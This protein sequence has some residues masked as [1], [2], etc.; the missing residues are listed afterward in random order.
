MKEKTVWKK[1]SG[2]D[3]AYLSAVNSV[4]TATKEHP[5]IF[6]IT[7]SRSSEKFRDVTSHISTL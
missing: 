2:I 5:R 7:K 3:W 6:S 4:S 1:M